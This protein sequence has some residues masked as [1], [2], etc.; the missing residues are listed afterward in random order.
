M[1]FRSFEFFLLEELNSLLIL[2]KVSSG[3][4]NPMRDN[5]RQFSKLGCV[6]GF[7]L[8]ADVLELVFNLVL[9]FY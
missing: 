1:R 6:E 4:A 2:L 3:T 7:I 8:L 5:P 9:P